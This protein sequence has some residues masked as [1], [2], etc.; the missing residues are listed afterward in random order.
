MIKSLLVLLV[1]I[2]SLNSAAQ[3]PEFDKLEM[4]FAQ[5]HYKAVHRKSNLLL[6][7]PSYDYSLLPTYYKSMSML[8]LAQN[9]LWLKRHSQSISEAL[10]LFL[11]VKNS[12]NGEMLF[13]AH[14]Y[15]L[16]WIKADLMSWASDL[17]RVGNNKAFTE[18]KAA[19]VKMYDGIPDLDVENSPVIGEPILVENDGVE[20]S[21]GASASRSMIVAN[22]KKHLGTPYVWAGNS[23]NGFDCSGFTSY[24]MKDFGNELPRRSEDQYSDGKKVKDKNV[25][26]GDLIFFSNGSGISHVG[27]V[28]SEKGQPIVMIHASSSKGVI[29]TDIESSEYWT[30]RVHGF[31]TYVN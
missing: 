22:A 26:K 7:N 31:A 4:L 30:K 23:P 17:K 3:Q 8:Q 20:E 9:D 13:N 14:M 5:K 6:D 2:I 12:P 28:I 1:G 19:L 16:N 15:E 25:Q 11:K 27:I 10:E 29:I 21:A 24:V 18:I